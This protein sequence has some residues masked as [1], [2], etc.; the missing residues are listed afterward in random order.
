MPFLLGIVSTP[1]FDIKK[2][3][4]ELNTVFL[5]SSRFF[6]DVWKIGLVKLV[7]SNVMLK[8]WDS[9]HIFKIFW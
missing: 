6:G 8:C 4:T 9:R 2:G 1:V 5:S 3:I 7:I